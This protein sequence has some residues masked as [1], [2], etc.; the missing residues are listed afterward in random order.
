MAA[1]SA[2]PDAASG[3]PLD[4]LAAA[5]SV[6]SCAIWSR[7]FLS[8]ASY[9]ASG[10][11]RQHMR[12]FLLTSVLLVPQAKPTFESSLTLGRLRMFFALLA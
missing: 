5:R 12:L 10:N 8:R 9:T 4:A 1:W 7:N 3:W 11:M 6:C 2:G